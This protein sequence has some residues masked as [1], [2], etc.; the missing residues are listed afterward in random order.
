MFTQFAKVIKI[1][2]QRVR[3]LSEILQGIRLIKYYTWE[4]FYMQKILAIRM[5]EIRTLRVITYV[6]WKVSTWTNGTDCL[7]SVY[8]AS[9]ISTVILVPVL[10]AVLSF[11][12]LFSCSHGL[13]L[14][15]ITDHL[16][17]H[18]A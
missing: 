1:T 18:W 17:P 7:A 6:L 12:R 8:R 3:L 10:A 13:L 16:L 11:V 5:P 15:R 4:S 14:K 9:L 2:D